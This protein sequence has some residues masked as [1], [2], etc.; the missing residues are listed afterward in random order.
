VRL[1]K[2]L[3]IVDGGNADEDHSND[4]GGDGGVGP[5]YAATI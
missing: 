1:I 3:Q 2:A 4:D 5:H